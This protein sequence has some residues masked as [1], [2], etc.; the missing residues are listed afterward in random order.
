MLGVI[1]AAIGGNWKVFIITSDLPNAGTSSQIY[2][3]LYGLHRSSAP[4]Y[5]YGT[6]GAQFQDGQKDIFTVSSKTC[7]LFYVNVFY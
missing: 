6:D 2:I 7:F 3:I 5:L 1:C 4:I